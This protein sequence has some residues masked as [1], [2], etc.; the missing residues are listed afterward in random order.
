MAVTVPLPDGC[1]ARLGNALLRVDWGKDRAQE[2]RRGNRVLLVH[3]TID[4]FAV[5]FQ[6]RFKLTQPKYALANRSGSVFAVRILVHGEPA[7]ITTA[8]QP[9]E[10]FQVAYTCLLYTSIG[11]DSAKIFLEP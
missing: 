2:A 1:V 8:I 11:V 6:Y 3:K 5:P 7:G 10:G 4:P 9:I